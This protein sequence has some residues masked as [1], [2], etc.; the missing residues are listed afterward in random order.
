MKFIL[1]AFVV[2]LSVTIYPF[3]RLQNSE[4]VY[5]FGLIEVDF[6]NRY[7]MIL[8]ALMIP[9]AFRKTEWLLGAYLTL[10]LLSTVS[11]RFPVTATYGT[12]MHNEGLLALLG[13]FGVYQAT[14]RCGIFPAL[15][16]CL[17]AVVYITAFIAALQ[18][19]YGNF[20]NFP[21]FKMLA[22]NAQI[23]AESWPIYANMGGPNNLGLFCSLFT[24]Y[25]IVRKKRLQTALLFAL[26]IGSQS[27]FAWLSVIITTAV[28]SRKHLLWM[29]VIALTLSV[30]RH[31]ILTERF[32]RS[33]PIHWPIRD[34]DL[35]GRAYFWKRAI[36][37]LK[38]S[39]IL[40]KG[41]STYAH[42]IPQFHKRGDAIGFYGHAI[43]RPHN[44]FINIWQSSGLLSL[45]ILG[46]WMR[47]K[48]LFANDASLKMGIIGYL[49]AVVFTDSVLCVTPYLSIFLGGINGS[50]D[51]KRRHGEGAGGSDL[52]DRP[53]DSNGAEA[54]LQHL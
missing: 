10:L 44:M 53:S 16:K 13:F 32:S 51:E 54:A 5:I 25:A 43:D 12:P 31:D 28:I 15:E 42:Y 45:L 35:S 36:P 52:G 49:I 17:D 29:A 3:E 39:I 48:L 9:F 2:V 14:R 7:R 33:F 20:A 50:N 18:L 11:S 30:F 34:G 40:G 8:V 6:F 4:L 1:C 41:P 21:L 19:Y 37:V 23:R 27:R 38:D 26:L 47:K 24:P 46:V 22:P